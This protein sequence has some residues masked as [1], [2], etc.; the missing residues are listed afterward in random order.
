[1]FEAGGIV[2]GNSVPLSQV[3]LDSLC[4]QGWPKCACCSLC[5]PLQQQNINL[6]KNKLPLENK[7][8]FQNI[9]FLDIITHILRHF[10]RDL[11]TTTSCFLNTITHLFICEGFLRRSRHHFHTSC[12]LNTIT[13]ILTCEEFCREIQAPRSSH[14][15]S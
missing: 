12:F 15:V 11:G 9:L 10:A 6:N 13:C 14:A 2:T 7:T 1:M 4:A 5:I 8:M 3:L